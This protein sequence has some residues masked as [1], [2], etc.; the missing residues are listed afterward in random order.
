MNE[1]PELGGEGYRRILS[2]SARDARL[3]RW[4]ENACMIALVGALIALLCSLAAPV[5]DWFRGSVGSWTLYV[6]LIIFVPLPFVFLYIGG[7]LLHR[8]IARRY[9]IL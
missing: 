3:Y 9:G 7:A 4:S 1:R 5:Q 8:H 6:R 2:G